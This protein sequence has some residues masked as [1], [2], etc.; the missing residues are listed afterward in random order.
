MP[1]AVILT[2]MRSRILQPACDH[3]HRGAQHAN[4]TRRRFRFD[5]CR[6]DPTVVPNFATPDLDHRSFGTRLDLWH[7]QEDAPGMVFWPWQ[8]AL[9]I[10]QSVLQMSFW[11]APFPF[12]QKPDVVRQQFR[13]L[14]QGA[15]VLGSYDRD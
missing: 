8:H 14:L 1:I 4:A 2:T 11:C 9:S 5:Y 13:G 15:Q 3:P 7:I 10:K 6:T 12:K